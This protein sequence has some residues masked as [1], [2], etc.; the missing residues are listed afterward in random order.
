MNAVFGKINEKSYKINLFKEKNIVIVGFLLSLLHPITLFLSMLSLLFFLRQNSKG[1]IKALLLITTRSI[2][3]PAIGISISNMQ[4]FKWILLFGF[5]FWIL[6]HLNI[7]DKKDKEKVK[8]YSFFLGVFVL[9]CVFTSFFFSSYPIIA[10]FKLFSYAIVYYSVVLGVASSYKEF[11]WMKYFI[12]LLMPIF[13]FSFFVVPLEAFRIVNNSFQGMLNQPNMFGIITALF[14]TAITYKFSYGKF[15]MKYN[16]ML[17]MCIIMLYLSDSRTGMIASFV[18]LSI[19]FFL[20]NSNLNIKIIFVSIT[21]GVILIILLLH[22]EVLNRL[23]Q[24]II[25]FLLKGNEE[26]ILFSREGQIYTFIQKFKSNP[27]FGTG[28]AVP[29]IPNYRVFQMRFD[30]LVEPG[31]LILAIMGD[32]GIIG[33]I[34]FLFLMIFIFIQNRGMKVVLYIAPLLISFGEMVFFSTN[35]MAVFLYLFYGVY[36]FDKKTID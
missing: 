19:Y 12:D 18:V 16:I 24:E 23:N 27:Y 13:L 5:S 36:M 3:S 4:L 6:F 10:I 28:F 2:L 7:T 35:N 9:Y 11:D 8:K 26:N 14:I 20:N 21:A 1:S 32:S 25:N 29:Y 17:I 34:L 15:N 22:P 31:N 30:V 33:A